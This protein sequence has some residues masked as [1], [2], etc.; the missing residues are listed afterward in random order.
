[1]HRPDILVA[2]STAVNTM[3]AQTGTVPGITQLFSWAYQ[4]RRYEH[5]DGHVIVAHILCY[6]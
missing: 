4:G 2:Q 5:K 1:M 3:A 6:S